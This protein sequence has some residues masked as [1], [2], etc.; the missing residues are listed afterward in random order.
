MNGS[1]SSCVDPFVGADPPGHSLCGPHLPHGIVRLGPDTLFP[2]P[3]SG[4]RSGTPILH[5]SHTH[6]SG[7]GGGG[8]YGNVGVMPF[9]GPLRTRLDGSDH[10]NEAAA[11]GYYAT[12]LTPSGIRV[13]LTATPRTGVHRYAFPGNVDANVLIDAGAVIQTGGMVPGDRREDGTGACTG[14]FIEFASETEIIGRGDFRAGWG[15]AFPYSVYFYVLFDRPV[16]QRMVSNH[17]GV[18]PFSIADGPECRAAAGFGNASEVELRVG[19]S[20]VSVAKARASVERESGRKDFDAIRREAEA[21]WERALARIRVEGGS[22]AHRTLFYTLFTRLLCMPTDL[23]VDDENPLWHSG[24]RHFWDF[25]TIWDSVRNANALI[26]LFDPEL[27]ADMLNCLIDVADHTG[28]LPDVW[29]AGHSGMI[30]GGCSPDILFCEAALKGIRGIDYVR[31]MRCMR[32]NNE[33]ESPDPYLYGRYLQDY[34][35][36]GYLSTNVRKN[37]V[38]RHLEYAYQ[39]WCIGRLADHLKQH[40]LAKVYYE[41]SRKAWNLWRDDIQ[42]FAPRHPDGQWVEPFDPAHCLPDSWNDPYFYEGTSWQWSFSVHH[43]FEGLIQRH[44]GDEA[45]IAH[46]DRFFDEGHYHSKETMLHVPYL[47]T[48]A[49]R[50]DRAAERVRACMDKYFKPTRDG[51]ADNEDMGCQS[52]FF[53]CSAMGLYPVMGQDVYLLTTPAFEKITVALGKS[54]DVLTIEAPGAGPD[55]RYIRRAWLDDKPLMRAWLRHGEIGLGGT[56]RF[57]LSDVPTP[58]GANQPPPS[59]LSDG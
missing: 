52:A 21:I 6:V 18:M 33:V 13:E 2:Q 48:Y 8:R 28:W 17:F 50:P 35:D 20:F 29:T 56:L 45:F 34:R 55:M 25:Y 51:L 54:G 39:D 19:I 9:T 32:K 7:T 14:G 43:D 3:T 15:H 22:D 42:F 27:E 30:Q 23:G 24:V 58:W 47:Y 10:E 26:S 11:P 46:L 1:C 59:P 31:A 4:Y 40:E 5:F 57:E 49:G 16:E 12:T 41:S 36:L 53:M 38:S 37:C 44:G